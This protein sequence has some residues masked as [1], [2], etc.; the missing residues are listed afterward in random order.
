MSFEKLLDLDFGYV[1][2]DVQADAV[3]VRDGA[4]SPAQVLEQQALLYPGPP[5]TFSVLEQFKVHGSLFRAFSVLEPLPGGAWPRVE[6]LLLQLP[7]KKLGVAAVD[8][9]RWYRR[10]AWVVNSSEIHAPMRVWTKS[11]HWPRR[12]Y[13]DELAERFQVIAGRLGEEAERTP[14]SA[15]RLALL[16]FGWRG[17]MGRNDQLQ[18]PMRKLLVGTALQMLREFRRKLREATQADVTEEDIECLEAALRVTVSFQS[19]WAGLK[20]L[21]QAL[22]FCVRPCVTTSLSYEPLDGADVHWARIP[23]WLDA[24]LFT[25]GFVEARADSKLTRTRTAYASYCADRLELS[26]GRTRDKRNKGEPLEPSEA[27]RI[28]YVR[29]LVELRETLEGRVP[30]V[31]AASATA[32]PAKSVRE[33]ARFAIKKLASSRKSPIQGLYAANWWMRRAQVLELGGDVDASAAREVWKRDRYRAKK[34]G[35]EFKLPDP[36]AERDSG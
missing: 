14:D 4:L 33:A 19:L 26:I 16:Q 9:F 10:W 21:L 1:P 22:R 12:L 3:R 24:L 8:S 11:A 13:A 32:D 17:Y 36:D 23:F 30:A 31:L 28:S 7:P 27:W 35:T 15:L 18:P 5:Q 29:A 34:L 6:E 25:F 2:P 20:E